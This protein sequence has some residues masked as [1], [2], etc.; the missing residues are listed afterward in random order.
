MEDC[1]IFYA[2]LEHR[3]R[4]LKSDIKEQQSKQR[5]Y[6]RLATL[7][8]DS[9]PLIL[10]RVRVVGTGGRQSRRS[11]QPRQPT[12]RRRRPDAEAVEAVPGL[13]NSRS[14]HKQELLSLLW[15]ERTLWT[16]VEEARGK[17]IRGLR[18]CTQRDCMLAMNKDKMGAVNIS[19]NFTRLMQ[20]KS[21]IRIMTEEDLAFHR[22]SM[23]MECE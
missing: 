11:L 8:T 5:L 21:T 14:V 9:R 16:E 1:L 20:G 17:T 18:R 7:Q 10:S 3:R 13:P 4:R 23:C 15:R 6:K 22:A 2:Q 12:L 19:T